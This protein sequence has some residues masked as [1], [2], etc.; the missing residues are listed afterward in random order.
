[1]WH[2]FFG[3]PK[4][5]IPGKDGRTF[6][7]EGMV[8]ERDAFEKMKDEFYDIRGWDVG[9]GLQKKSTLVKLGLEEVADS[10]DEAGLLR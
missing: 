9:S 3:N 8:M 1:M 10:L 5:L 6:S 2:I 7:R 4:M